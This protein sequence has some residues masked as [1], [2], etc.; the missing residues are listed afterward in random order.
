MNNDNP[1]SSM[2]AGQIMCQNVIT[3][4]SDWTVNQLARFLTDKSISGAPVVS[5]NGQFVGVVSFSDIVR[6]TG[7]GLVEKRDDSFYNKEMDASLSPEEQQAFHGMLDDPAFVDDSI[8][9]NDIMTPMMFEVSLETPLMQVAEAMVK[10]RIHRVMVT[11][12]HAIKGVISAL[13]L[14][15]VITL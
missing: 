8:L 6:Q 7:S 2:T 1:L 4:S 5:S 11:E 9:V 14:L 13:D 15:K 3:V 12:G 10:G